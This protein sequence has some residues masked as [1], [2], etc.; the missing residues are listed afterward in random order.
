[1]SKRK[2]F[3]IILFIIFIIIVLSIIISLICSVD[4]NKLKEIEK[5]NYSYIDN[6]TI[7]EQLPKIFS[8]NASNMKWIY[9]DINSDGKKD[10]I[11]LDS[12]GVLKIVGIFV[13][14]G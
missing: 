13:I 9:K 8:V 14:K 10:L 5:G 1:M 12:Y 3:R 7:Q 4:I 6:E 2:L 11:L